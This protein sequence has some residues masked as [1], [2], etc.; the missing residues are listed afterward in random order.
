MTK[1]EKETVL[2]ALSE[3][4][5]RHQKAADRAHKA[6]DYDLERAEHAKANIAS[7]ICG[8]WP[9][10]VSAQCGTVTI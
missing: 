5:Y 7:A 2:A 9:G 8:Y 6:K 1:I 3:Y 10:V 4:A